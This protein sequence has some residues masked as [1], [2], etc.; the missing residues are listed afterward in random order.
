[1]FPGSL[2]LSQ[3][4]RPALRTT[5]NNDQQRSPVQFLV[6][7]KPK[8]WTNTTPMESPKGSREYTFGEWG[9]RPQSDTPPGIGPLSPKTTA[10]QDRRETAMMQ[11]P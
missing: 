9:K 1:M 7:T 8:T 3:E 5:N 4:G 10:E 2:P 11:D 6:S